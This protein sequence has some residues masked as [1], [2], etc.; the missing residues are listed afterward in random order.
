[1]YIKVSNIVL[2]RNQL[3]RIVMEKSISW[4]LGMVG[5]EK[6]DQINILQASLLAMKIAIEKLNPSPDFLLVDG[7]DFIP[8]LEIE[9]RPLIKGDQKS[10]SIASASIL[11]KVTRDRMMK[12]YSQKYPQYGFHQN[13]GYGT[14]IHRKALEIHGVCFLHRK[15][16]L[17][18]RFT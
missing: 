14:L 11:A 8:D 6:I 7:R 18:G 12:L 2:Q 9:Q 10:I 3:C 4:G 17:K 5:P 1:M 13:K 15:S 16:F